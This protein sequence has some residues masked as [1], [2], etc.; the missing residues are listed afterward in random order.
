MQFDTINE[1]LAFAL[2]IAVQRV[3]LSAHPRPAVLRTAGQRTESEALRVIE[4]AGKCQRCPGGTRRDIL[5]HMTP[6]RPFGDAFCE[7]LAAVSARA[8]Q[9]RLLWFRGHGDSSWELTSGLHRQFESLAATAGVREDDPKRTELMRLE[10]QN[11]YQRFVV[12]A[13]PFLSEAERTDWGV[14]LAM[15]HYRHSTRFLD[16]TES[17]ACALFFAQDRKRESD[18]AIF[19]MD[20]E[21]IR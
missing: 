20:P 18:G 16:W 7:V 21:D 14:I 1:E 17:F 2:M 4:T 9:H 3:D 12:D 5:T 8:S 10:Y 6:S 13:W 19:M 11:A 15:Q